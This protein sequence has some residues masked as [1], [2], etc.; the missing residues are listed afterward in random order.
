MSGSMKSSITVF[1]PATVFT[2][3]ARRHIVG[4]TPTS[5]RPCSSGL[6]RLQP[7][8]ASLLVLPA[9]ANRQLNLPRIARPRDLA[10]QPPGHRRAQRIRAVVQL[11]VAKLSVRIQELR[12]IENIEDLED[13]LN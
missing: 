6:T 8:E 12:V 10:K 11:R 3:Q 2:S 9:E 7:S 4:A 13:E 5:I 1:A